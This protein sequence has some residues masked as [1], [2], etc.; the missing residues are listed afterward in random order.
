MTVD[1][2]TPPLLLN[3]P[4]RLSVADTL[5]RSVQAETQFQT[6]T[7]ID[8]LQST[9]D[10]VFQARIIVNFKDE[11][12]TKDYYRITMYAEV[13][14]E[15][16]SIAQNDLL[17]NGQNTA[18]TTRNRWLNL[19][20]V[21]VRLYHIGLEWYDFL[22]SSQ[23]AKVGAHNPL[24]EPVSVISNVVGGKGIFTTLNVDYAE[25]VIHP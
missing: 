7:R 13:E 18:F 9:F 3:T 14:E 10:D 23:K 16:F 8:S 2:P 4:F 25:I 22:V 19:D 12:S 21:Q 6:L 24:V 17:I 15:D 5:G 1:F 11:E 20:T